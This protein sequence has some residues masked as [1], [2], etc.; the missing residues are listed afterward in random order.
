VLPEPA[1]ITDLIFGSVSVKTLPYFSFTDIFN[2]IMVKFTKAG[3]TGRRAR[4]Q[5]EE[6][7]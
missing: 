6:D 3:A 2:F 5:K 7:A 4:G 1:V